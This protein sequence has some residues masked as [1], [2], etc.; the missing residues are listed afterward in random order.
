MFPAVRGGG[1]EWHVGTIIIVTVRD[2]DGQA[3]VALK[4]AYKFFD[5][6]PKEGWNLGPPALNVGGPCDR[7]NE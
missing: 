2:Y 4:H 5:A 1:R 6:P 3:V 7:L